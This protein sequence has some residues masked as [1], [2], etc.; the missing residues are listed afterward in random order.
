M[1]L[2]KSVSRIQRY[3]TSARDRAR[4]A[5]LRE[6]GVNRLSIGVQS[7]DA[8]RLSFLGRLHDPAGAL[9]ALRDAVAEMPRVSADL[10]FGSPGQRAGDFVDEL[11][12][13]LD[14]LLGNAVE[15]GRPPIAVLIEW[16]PDHRLA[17]SVSDHGDGIPEGLESE[18]RSPFVKLDRARGTT[19]CGLGLAI[20]QQ[21]VSR[22]GGEV[23][24]LRE[25]GRFT[26]VATVRL[27]RNNSQ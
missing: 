3:I 10:M 22:V 17:L 21:L 25:A 15:H 12:R 7:L 11:A 14:N 20:V 19:G 26:V 23:S 5:G 24:F 4:A 1:A 2:N 9:S 8:A 18:A 16:R 6:V 27:Q 13:V